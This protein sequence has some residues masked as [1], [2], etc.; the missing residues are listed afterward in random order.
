MTDQLRLI[1]SAF[2]LP[3]KT[4]IY[5]QLFKKRSV[6]HLSRSYSMEKDETQRAYET[7]D[8]LAVEPL[9]RPSQNG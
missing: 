2:V 8:N 1:R 3:L 4:I 7:N 9:R 6:V 5:K